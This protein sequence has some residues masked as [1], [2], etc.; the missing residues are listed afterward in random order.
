[1]GT[2]GGSGTGR[3]Q[4]MRAMI[5]QGFRNAFSAMFPSGG[6]EK[7]ALPPEGK[8]KPRVE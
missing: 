5:S 2:P 7:T 6:T 3:K 4:T 8:I 1:M